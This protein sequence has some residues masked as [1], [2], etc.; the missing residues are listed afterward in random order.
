MANPGRALADRII[1]YY[2]QGIGRPVIFTCRADSF[3]PQTGRPH[4]DVNHHQ[5]VRWDD[6]PTAVQ[7]DDL[8]LTIRNAL[9]SKG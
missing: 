3:N 7:L 1:T 4:F 9:L 6:P 8:S 5:C 2:A